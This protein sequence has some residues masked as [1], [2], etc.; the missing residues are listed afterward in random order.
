MFIFILTLSVIFLSAFA[1]KSIVTIAA[2][3][4]DAAGKS[5]AEIS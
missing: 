3:P 4:Q 1:I 2:C 5:A